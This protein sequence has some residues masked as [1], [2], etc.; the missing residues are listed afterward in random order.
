MMI[1]PIY[2]LIV[3]GAIII[4][5]QP[6]Y[7]QTINV[8][9]TEPCFLNYTAGYQ[10]LD[11]CGFDEDYLEASVLGFDYVTGGY[12]SMILAGVIIVAVYIK[13]HEPMYA[14]IAGMAF[15]PVTLF[16]FPEVFLNFVA[17][18]LVIAAAAGI[19]Y[20]IK[21]VTSDYNS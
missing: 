21:Q 15:V 2:S 3:L 1:N 13:Y 6:A 11:N 8:T 9:Q 17:V 20:L 7:A 14:I 16:L 10:I 5:V 19:F 4:F 18:M 12:F